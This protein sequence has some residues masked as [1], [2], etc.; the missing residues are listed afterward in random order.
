MYNRKMQKTIFFKIQTCDGGKHRR[1][2]RPNGG[3]YVN[4]TQCCPTLAAMVSQELL[5]L[6][7]KKKLQPPLEN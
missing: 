4:E 7:Y 6:Q 5:I 2:D 1:K 3:L